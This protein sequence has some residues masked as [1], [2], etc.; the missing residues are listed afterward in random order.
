[1]GLKNNIVKCDAVNK[2]SLEMSCADGGYDV[3]LP[4]IDVVVKHCW[5][6]CS[7]WWYLSHTPSIGP[8]V[9]GW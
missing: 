9:E 5:N 3:C 7:L 1:V 4:L 8:E 6:V 2:H